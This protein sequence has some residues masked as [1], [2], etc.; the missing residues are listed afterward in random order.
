MNNSVNSEQKNKE[1][2]LHT[3]KHTHR[4]KHSQTHYMQTKV[5]MHTHTHCWAVLTDEG[6]DD[7]LHALQEAGQVL[8]GGVERR[9]VLD[10]GHGQGLAR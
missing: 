4:H 8:S 7:V 1:E 5:T 2:C 3:R 6:R 10:Q 9:C